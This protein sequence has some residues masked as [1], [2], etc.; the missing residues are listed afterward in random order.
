MTS[1]D[2]KL[3]E[4]NQDQKH[5]KA[6]FIICADLKCIID[7]IDGCKNNPENSSARKVNKHTPSGISISTI[8]SFKSIEN[9]HKVYRGKDCMKKFYES[10]REH[11]M[12]IINFK[13]NKMKLLK[14]E[15]QES[16]DNAKICHICQENFE[17]KYVK[18]KKY[19]QVRDHC[20]YT[21]E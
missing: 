10:L 3:I 11:V 19:C 9:K 7:K 6:P 12:K 14:K 4:F 20:H 15:Q 16:Y 17:N 13:S 21:G 18:N 5:D 2:T 8:L 1:E